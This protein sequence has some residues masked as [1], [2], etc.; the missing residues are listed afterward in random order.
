M[1]IKPQTVRINRANDQIDAETSIL[2][3]AE[4]AASRR[5]NANFYIAEIQVPN[6]HKLVSN[7][8]GVETFEP[9]FDDLNPKYQEFE[10]LSIKTVG[11]ETGITEEV[12]HYVTPFLIKRFPEQYKKF[13]LGSDYKETVSKEQAKMDAMAAELEQMKAQMAALLAKKEK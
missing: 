12:I 4:L 13:K 2:N 7:I 6:E 11:K 1:N 10:M 8:N 3:T 9:V 5:L